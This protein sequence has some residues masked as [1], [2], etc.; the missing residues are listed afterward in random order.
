MLDGTASTVAVIPESRQ[1]LSARSSVVEI[2]GIRDASDAVVSACECVPEPSK[3][4]PSRVSRSGR[5]GECTV[6]GCEEPEVATD[7]DPRGVGPE[8]ET[9]V[10]AQEELGSQG[11]GSGVYRFR[12]TWQAK[13]WGQVYSDSAQLEPREIREAA[14]SS[15]MGVQCGTVQG[16]D[17]P[18]SPK[19]GSGRSQE[20]IRM[21]IEEPEKGAN[22]EDSSAVQ[23]DTVQ[24]CDKPRS[25]ERRT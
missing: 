13:A 1:E 5:V 20:E 11:T 22:H 10:E 21:A 6:Q 25:I 17:K 24:G 4:T 14:A 3:G 12:P 23:S 15:L 2:E 16:Y 18:P 9:P 19:R 7:G 8:Q